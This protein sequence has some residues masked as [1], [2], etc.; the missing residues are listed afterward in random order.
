MTYFQLEPANKIVQARLDEVLAD[1]SIYKGSE[2]KAKVGKEVRLVNLFYWSDTPQGY[3]YWKA[4]DDYHVCKVIAERP[5]T[6]E[7]LHNPR[8]RK[9]CV[10]T[11]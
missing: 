3:E 4:V 9:I 6:N 1:P 11:K 2:I 8:P 7:L 10:N 5:I